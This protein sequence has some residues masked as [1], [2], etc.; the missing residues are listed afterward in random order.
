MCQQITILACDGAGHRIAQCEHGTIHLFWV[1]VNIFLVPD[2]LLTLLALLQSW[3]PGH[4][5]AES[6]G[7]MLRRMT[8]GHLQ[9]WC[10][11]GGL[12]LDD[13][14]L[15]RL[16]DLLWYAVQQLNLL[17]P[18]RRRPAC[19]W[20]DEYQALTVASRGSEAWN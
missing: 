20:T 1:R 11:C 4:C 13:A 15:C 17:G 3:Q 10:A 5:F 2:D 18:Q 12:L 7:F 6:D 19:R 14:D 9:L 8:S 16:R